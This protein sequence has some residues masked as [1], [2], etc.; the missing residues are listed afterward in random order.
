MSIYC[1]MF[2]IGNQ[3]LPRCK[4]MKKLGRGGYSQDDSK[5]CTCG[6]C[7]IRYQGSHVLP[8][9]KAE[10]SGEIGI[11]CIPPHITRNGRDNRGSERLH[12]WL[13]VHLF[14]GLP[15]DTVILTKKQVEKFRDA[16]N[17]WLERT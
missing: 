8:S 14:A 6:S 9:N 11:S 12:P 7:P 17:E 13:R 10:R 15:S 16:L 3:H 4:R 1:S 5:P 2:E